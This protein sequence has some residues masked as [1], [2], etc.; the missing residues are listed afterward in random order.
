MSATEQKTEICVHIRW[1]ILRD[2]PEVFEIEQKSFEFP[3]SEEDFIHCLSQGNSIGMVVE[4]EDQVIGFMI[5]ELCED[6]IHVPNFAVHHN[7]QGQKIG[8]QMVAKLI[9]IL[10]AQRKSRI[11]LE[12]REKNLDAQL[13]FKKCGF[14]AV[15]IL[16]NFYEDTPEDAYVMQYRY[17]T[18]TNKIEKPENLLA[19]IIG[20]LTG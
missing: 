5:Y 9:A 12:V 13:F 17:K 1:M 3:W 2:I 14:M 7:Y 11:V 20:R 18:P 16:R 15:R 4:H 10:L 8:S 19:R 6:R